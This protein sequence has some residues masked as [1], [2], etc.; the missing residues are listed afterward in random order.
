M[1]SVL[2]LISFSE[3]SSPNGKEV[4]Y[5][6]VSEKKKCKSP[7]WCFSPPEKNAQVDKKKNNVEIMFWDHSW[8]ELR[9]CSSLLS[10]TF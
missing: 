4:N 5:R 9:L 2:F 3:T 6:T 7:D 1:K 10:T 8:S